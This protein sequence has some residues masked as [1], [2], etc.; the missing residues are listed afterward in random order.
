MC[1]IRINTVELTNLVGVVGSPITQL[2]RK[3]GHDNNNNLAI[4]RISSEPFNFQLRLL[5]MIMQ[6][7]DGLAGVM[8]EFL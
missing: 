2:S 8:L 6:N 5:Q 4:I 3:R 1:D 7:L